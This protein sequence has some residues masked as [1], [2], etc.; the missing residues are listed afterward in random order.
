[1]VTAVSPY[2]DYRHTMV[3]A[4][5]RAISLATA[6]ACHLMMHTALL[7]QQR[8]PQPFLPTPQKLPSQTLRARPGTH[9]RGTPTRQNTLHRILSD[10][11][12]TSVQNPQVTPSLVFLSEQLLRTSLVRRL[13]QQVPPEHG[14]MRR[15]NSQRWRTG[16]QQMQQNGTPR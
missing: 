2:R 9:K 3:T 6:F 7:S 11:T 10:R 5:F 14:E 16:I 8:R 12:H 13:P 4:A 1:M 15:R